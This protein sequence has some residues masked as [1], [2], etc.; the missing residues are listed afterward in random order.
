MAQTTTQIGR[1]KVAHPDLGFDA[2]DGGVALHSA[3]STMFTKFSDHPNARYFKFSNVVAGTPLTMDVNLGK[4]NFLD[5]KYFVNGVEDFDAEFRFRERESSTGVVEITPTENITLLEII[6]TPRESAQKK[7]GYVN[8]KS[9]LNPDTLKYNAQNVTSLLL[10]VSYPVQKIRNFPEL[11]IFLTRGAYSFDGINWNTT[12]SLSASIG[13]A[14]V[15]SP[16]ERAVYGSYNAGDKYLANRTTDGVTMETSWYTNTPMA[17]VNANPFIFESYRRSLSKPWWVF[18]A[19]GY[20]TTA[21]TFE[22]LFTTS[23]EV[24][25]YP[26]VNVIKIGDTDRFILACN[27]GCYVE[28]LD[29]LIDTPVNGIGTPFALPEGLQVIG[30]QGDTG[31]SQRDPFLGIWA[32]EF[33][34]AVLVTF[35]AENVVDS[36]YKILT[37]KNGSTWD[38]SLTIPAEYDIKGMAYGSEIHTLAV[39][40]GSSTA[41]RIYLTSDGISWIFH[42]LP[43]GFNPKHI[44]YDGNRH[45]FLV[46][47]MNYTAHAVFFEPARSSVSPELAKK[48]R[49]ALELSYPSGTDV[50]ISVPVATTFTKNYAAILGKSEMFLLVGNDS[51]S[52]TKAAYL[53]GGHSVAMSL[54]TPSGNMSAVFAHPTKD[55]AIISAETNATNKIVLYN[56]ANMYGWGTTRTVDNVVFCKSWHSSG[57]YAHRAGG[58]GEYFYNPDLSNTGWVSFTRSSPTYTQFN[59]LIETIPLVN[60]NDTESLEDIFVIPEYN[61]TG[62]Q[63]RLA[64]TWNRTS[65]STVDLPSGNTGNLTPNVALISGCFWA[66]KI[67]RL[68]VMTYYSSNIN[69]PLYWSDLYWS[70]V[71]HYKVVPAMNGMSHTLVLDYHKKLYSENLESVGDN[72]CPEGISAARVYP[73]DG[74][75]VCLSS[76]GFRFLTLDYGRSW[77]QLSTWASSAFSRRLGAVL[78]PAYGATHLDMD[79]IQNGDV[80]E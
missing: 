31:V 45:R 48:A 47:G 18:F 42:E 40:G 37:S 38:I 27:S 26:Y 13:D 76:N 17:P 6:F 56:A 60:R 55:I 64:Y 8:T 20:F 4:Y 21:S 71:L 1:M 66:E 36:N 51:A 52:P 58:S 75:I 32:K 61:T 80:T 25:D 10:T 5:S 65:W 19:G 34:L 72:V 2:S 54:T 9:V 29:T 77:L 78:S 22:G 15:W 67:Q 30:D 23:D 57:F 12:P 41:S 33:G 16:T 28:T 74:I 14:F 69:E 3:L 43:S 59:S 62:V 44:V 73:K 24:W 39:L 11:G 68:V 63:L 46:Y 79:Y 35:T 50:T 53:V 7:Y 49:L 70:D